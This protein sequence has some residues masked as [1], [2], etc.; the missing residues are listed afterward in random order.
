MRELIK[1]LIRTYP[2]M[3]T[4]HLLA[5][6]QEPLPSEPK[7]TFSLTEDEKTLWNHLY[8]EGHVYN[9]YQQTV[10]HGVSEED[11]QVMRLTLGLSSTPSSI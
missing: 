8:K 5:D 7:T 11:L 2:S 6:L 3:K 4:A 10:R 9:P 1:L